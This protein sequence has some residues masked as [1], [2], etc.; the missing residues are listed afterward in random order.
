[1]IIS[2][3]HGPSGP[4]LC[5]SLRLRCSLLADHKMSALG[6]GIASVQYQ[7]P[8]AWCVSRS[9]VAIVSVF[10]PGRGKRLILPPVFRPPQNNTSCHLRVYVQRNVQT[11]WKF[12]TCSLFPLFYEGFTRRLRLGG[13]YHG[14]EGRRIHLC[15][16]TR[17]VP[18]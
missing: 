7:Y 6:L 15:F 11:P 5:G 10:R 9:R 3:N 2:G 12:R 8:A 17:F 16:M 13:P 1:M 18:I 4:V 14:L